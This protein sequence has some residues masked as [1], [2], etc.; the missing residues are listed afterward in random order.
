MNLCNFGKVA[1]ARATKD[2]SILK[3]WNEQK[4]CKD[5]PKYSTNLS[6]KERY[7]NYTSFMTK[8]TKMMMDY[9]TFQI[10]VPRVQ[11]YIKNNNYWKFNKKQNEHNTFFEHFSFQNWVKL[12]ETEKNQHTIEDCKPCNTIHIN[13]TQLHMS[14]SLETINVH[15]A[16]T[17]ATKSVVCGKTPASGLKAVKTLVQMVQP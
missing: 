15:K 10:R 3:S 4:E 12:S 11:K 8:Y 16:C 13:F 1:I 2:L 5:P 7:S 17:T 14:A 6:L 9:G